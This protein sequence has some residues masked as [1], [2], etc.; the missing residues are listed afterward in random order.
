[1]YITGKSD[2]PIHDGGRNICAYCG[3]WKRDK[4]GSR[5]WSMDG[6][7]NK[8]SGGSCLRGSGLAS[9]LGGDSLM[10]RRS[11]LDAAAP[12]LAGGAISAGVSLATTGAALW[13]NSIQLSH[14]AD[15][16]TTQIVNGAAIKL[17]AILDGYNASPRSCADQAA[18]LAAVDSIFTWLMS[19]QG[20]GNGAYGSAGNACISDRFGDSAKW[21][22]TAYYRDPIANDP[23][24]AG[25]AA[26]LLAS[27]P[28][29]VL[30]SAIANGQALIS[31]SSQQTSAGQFAGGVLTSG[32]SAGFSFSTPVLGLPVWM[33]GAG[34][35]LVLILK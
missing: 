13:M 28:D 31:G 30:Q 8:Y 20:C 10:Y 29:A 33:W 2:H 32:S 6:R 11:G 24:A 4:F 25:C 26:S 22:W 23:Q 15:T 21:P 3:G 34:L 7:R 19:P 12:S 5:G 17:Q 14:Q 16:A 9:C 27:N 35:G 18:A 1:M